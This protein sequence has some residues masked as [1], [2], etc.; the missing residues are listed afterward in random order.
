MRIRT[1]KP[2]FFTNDQ[3]A[4]LKP[5][6]RLLFIGLWCMADVAG[7]LEDRPRRI[8]VALLPYDSH[9]VET[10]LADLASAG[11]I[12][13]YVANGVR[14]IQ[15]VNFDKHQRIMGKEAETEST[16]PPFTG[17]T[18]GK[19]PGNNGETPENAGR[20]GKGKEGKGTDS[21]GA[22]GGVGE[23]P[24]SDPI[25]DIPRELQT[26]EF[27]KAWR[28]WI[29]CR[30]AHKKPKS[31]P[32]LFN[33]QLQ[34]LVQFGAHHAVEVLNQSMRNGWMGLFP[35]K[36]NGFAVQAKPQTWHDEEAADLIAF[37]ARMEKGK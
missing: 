17:E 34:W 7:R 5:L 31:W 15:V 10:A 27:V 9:D 36:G 1:I 19:H 33:A 26:P 35:P 21:A 11:F 22:P 32:A 16:F 37:A 23:K 4:E 14:V 13:R 20:E 28:Q 6:T 8:K 3:V 2:S 29:E 12:K 30:K 25:M 24:E 18:T